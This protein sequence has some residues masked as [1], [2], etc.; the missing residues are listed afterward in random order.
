MHMD[1]SGHVFVIHGDLLSISCNE[2]LVPTDMNKRVEEY[3]DRW[4]CSPEAVP[5]WLDKEER[6]TESALIE[7]QL[8]RY[9]SVG[10]IQDRAASDWLE[11]GVRAALEGCVQDAKPFHPGPGLANRA[12]W[13]VAIPLFGTRAGGFDAVR[14]DALQAVLS[15]SRWAAAQGIDVAIVCRERSAYAALQARRD[16]R[17][18]WSELSDEQRQEACALGAEAGVGSLALFIGAGVSLAAG[19][20][21]WRKLIEGAASPDLRLDPAFRRSLGRSLPRAASRVR[22]SFSSEAEFE[23]HIRAQ[24]PGERHAIAHGLLASMRVG[25]AVTT[26][27][28]RLYELAAEVP[29]EGGLSVLPWKR[30]PGRPPWLLKLHG[31]LDSGDLVVTSEDYRR[32]ARDHRVLG[33]VVQALLVT[34]HLVFVGYSLRDRDFVDLALQVSGALERSGALHRRIGTVLSLAPGSTAI[35][36]VAD[37]KSVNVGD[38]HPEETLDDA[39]MLEIFLDCMAWKAAEGESSWV[40]DERYESLLQDQAE[41]ELAE[42][43]RNIHVPPGDRWRRLTD[44]LRAYG[45][46][47]D[48]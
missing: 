43:L 14:G 44:L 47:S 26:N 24:L 23:N 5:A 29:L 38:Q 11:Q 17:R 1:T 18:F 10:T 27:F 35:D 34:R 21:S 13:L 25:E 33:S 22:D 12:K 3:W 16:L 41:R 32:F 40:L 45:A 20:P 7:G 42:Q 39:R 19:L 46:G 37:I 15:A 2:V 9:V 48:G 36:G 8:V 31:D 28:D 30:Q 6:V 4:W